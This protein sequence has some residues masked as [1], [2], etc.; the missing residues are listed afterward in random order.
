MPISCHFIG[1][2]VTRHNPHKQHFTQSR[3]VCLDI[4]EPVG[5]SHLFRA[6]ASPCRQCLTGS[7][8]LQHKQRG[9]FLVE[10]RLPS[11]FWQILYNHQNIVSLSL[12][13]WGLELYQVY[14]VNKASDGS[15]CITHREMV[16]V[17][18]ASFSRAILWKVNFG[19]RNC[20]GRTHYRLEALLAAEPT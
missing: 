2:Q 5:I 10:W 18:L 4:V 6:F 3:D 15:A 13:T 14:T 8:Q 17:Y 12:T 20:C 16:I 11:Q 19:I 1:L 7:W 9:L